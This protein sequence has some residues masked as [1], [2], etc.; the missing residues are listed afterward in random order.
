MS[1][2][3]AWKLSQNVLGQVNSRERKKDKTNKQTKNHST[4]AIGTS[5]IFKVA[6][7]SVDLREAI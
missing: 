4:S 6:G 5:A 1:D 7:E 2:H 3:F